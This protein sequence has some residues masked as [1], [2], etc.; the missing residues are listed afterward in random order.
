MQ[1]GDRAQALVNNGH[2]TDCE[3]IDIKGT[4][5]IVAGDEEMRRARADGRNPI[6]ISL[7]CDLVKEK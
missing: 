7:R 2:W 6:G 1:I 5:V 3:V 4:Y